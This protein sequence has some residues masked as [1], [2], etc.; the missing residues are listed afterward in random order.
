MDKAISMGLFDKVKSRTES[1][2]ADRISDGIVNAIFKKKKKDEE[3]EPVAPAQPQ[4]QEEPV[5][6]APVQPQVQPEQVQVNVSASAMDPEQVQ[7]AMGM[8]Y[9]TK[10]CPECQAVC[11]NAPVTCPYCGADLKAVRPMTPEELEK[12]E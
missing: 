7:K 11:F 12:L 2:A 1:K 9:N 8:A 6:A 10:R 5:Q 4:V 3:P